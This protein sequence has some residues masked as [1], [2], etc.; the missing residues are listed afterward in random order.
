MRH[1]GLYT[2]ERA[3]RQPPIVGIDNPPKRA[4]YAFAGWP[5]ASRVAG[6]VTDVPPRRPAPTLSPS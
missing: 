1:D 5:P 3:S 6:A 2:G 4:E